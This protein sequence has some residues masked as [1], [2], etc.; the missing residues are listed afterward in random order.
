VIAVDTNILIYSHRPDSPWHSEAKLRVRELA[1]GETPWVLLWQCLHEF[2]GVVT[3]PRVWANPSPL[4]DAFDQV[5]AWLNAP[6]AILAT[7]GL[8]YWNI[9]RDVLTESGVTGPRIHDARIAALCLQHG[10]TT[11]WSAD[12][13]FSRFGRLKVVNP[14]VRKR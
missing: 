5:E 8:G 4:R 1:E 13:D 12:R 11:L 3:N 14:L 2:I 6:T 9:L 7:E 10:V